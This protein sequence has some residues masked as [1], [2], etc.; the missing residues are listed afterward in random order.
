LRTEPIVTLPAGLPT[1]TLPVSVAEVAPSQT[2]PV[3]LMVIDW[4]EFAVS[5]LVVLSQV[6]PVTDWL[7]MVMVQDPTK[8]VIVMVHDT[9]LTSTE[10]VV[11]AVMFHDVEHDTDALPRLLVQPLNDGAAEVPL[12]LVVWATAA[13]PLV[14]ASA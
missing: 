10:V 2:V 14:G 4:P 9:L 6:L 11:C 8:G 5:V 3:S 7:L 12:E 13:L 1:C